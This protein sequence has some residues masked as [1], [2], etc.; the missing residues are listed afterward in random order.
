[1]EDELFFEAKKYLSSKVAGQRA[2][3]THD[4]VSRLARQGKIPGRLVGRTWYVEEDSFTDFLSAHE[5]AK[6]HW[7]DQLSVE[8]KNE[9]NVADQIA[10][11]PLNQPVFFGVSLPELRLYATALSIAIVLVIGPYYLL[12]TVGTEGVL[13][14]LTSPMHSAA[15]LSSRAVAG[16]G[17]TVLS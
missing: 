11:R 16:G 5:Q 7:Y 14:L 15:S 9:Q 3:Y 1:M 13:A 2:G 17:E 8:R 4:Y 10:S 6:R 12:R